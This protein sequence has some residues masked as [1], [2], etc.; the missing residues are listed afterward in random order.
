MAVACIGIEGDTKV[1]ARKEFRV[2]PRI[3]PEFYEDDEIPEGPDI[4][5]DT[6]KE[7][8]YDGGEET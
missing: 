4:P 5:E 2:I 8:I 3:K 1:I 6:D 7:V